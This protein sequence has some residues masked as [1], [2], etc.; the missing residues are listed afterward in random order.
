M[1]KNYF[2]IAFRNLSREILVTWIN[3]GGLGLGLACSILMALLIKHE[4]TY[5]RFHEKHDR[6]FR[7]VRQR[8]LPSGNATDFDIWDTMHPP[9]V[10]D[11]LREGVAGVVRACAFTISPVGLF[12]PD[13]DKPIQRVGLVSDSFFEMFTFP[14]VSGSPSTA[15]SR[16]DGVVITET[17]ARRIFGDANGDYQDPIGQELMLLRM[18][19]VVTGV[20]ADAPEKSSLKFDAVIHIDANKGFPIARGGADNEIAHWALASIY[21]QADKE[22]SARISENI[23]RWNGKERLKQ[24]GEGSLRLILQ[25]LRDVYRNTEIPNKNEL[26]AANPEMVKILWALTII[27]LFAACSNYSIMSIS[28]CSRRATEV[29]L[30]NV[31]GATPGQIMK[32]F[33]CEAL[34]LNFLGLLLAIAI[35]ETFLPVFNGFVHRDLTI[36]YVEDGPILLLLLLLV[37]LLAGSYS[38]VALSRL[39]PVSAMKGQSG[40]GR[41]SRLTRTLIVLQFSGSIALMIS[42]GVMFRQTGFIRNKNLGYNQEQVVIVKANRRVAG[43]Y[44][45][46]ILKDPR[47]AGATVSDRTLTTSSGYS[48]TNYPLR[49]G[50]MVRINLIG[51][52]A[53]YLRTMEIPLLS[54]RNF[55]EDHPSDREQAVM[56]NKTLASQLNIA[57]PVGEILSGTDGLNDPVIVG[58]VRDFHYKSLHQTIEP[59]VMRLGKFNNNPSLLVRIHRGKTLETID[60]LKETWNTVAPDVPFRFSFLDDNL[61]RQYRDDKRWSLILTYSAVFT[62]V[63]SCF[64]LLGLT[65]VAVARRTKEIGIRKVLGASA[66]SVIWLLSGDFV[67]LSLAAN[68]IAWPAAYWAMS[69]WLGNFAYH[70]E[71]GIGVFVLASALTLGIAQL[72]IFAQTFKV[73]HRNPVDALRYE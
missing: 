60:V 41:R 51:I 50:T 55:S 3:I 61:N 35:A 10:A 18:N 68:L 30:R 45:R 67:R 46:E 12:A 5:D 14:F 69:R 23:N 9:W 26:I 48:W 43:I 6:L 37:G 62:L 57:D 22:Q 52:D 20:L 21:V 28:E 72:T 42:A 49:A 2:T 38:A 4:L 31:L 36:V 27:V 24:E 58:M 71:P 19:F 39:K 40:L 8:F 16:P 15:L 59:L 63:I 66:S 25:P 17:T 33:W 56:I 70:I 53:D 29:G 34:L 44:K 65:S 13:G 47:I 11:E 32:Q 54:G 1:L 64:G 7:V 73:A